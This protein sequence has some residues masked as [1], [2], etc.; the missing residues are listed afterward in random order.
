MYY[1]YVSRAGA[2]IFD[3]QYIL[4]LLKLNKL[5]RNM[6]NKMIPNWAFV[7]QTVKGRQMTQPLIDQDM[8]LISIPLESS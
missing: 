1:K 5:L 8:K 7:L 4:S 3:I 2:S 6:L